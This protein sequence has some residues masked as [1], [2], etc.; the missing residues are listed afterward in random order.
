MCAQAGE[1]ARPLWRGKLLT[2]N[3]PTPEHGLEGQIHQTQAGQEE[4]TPGKGTV[5]AKS[6]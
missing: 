2:G 5:F 1:Q 3:R 6:S 4:D